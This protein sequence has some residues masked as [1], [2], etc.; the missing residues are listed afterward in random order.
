MKRLIAFASVLIVLGPACGKKGDPRAPEL[1][2][3]QVIKNLTARPDRTGVVL[4]WSRPAEYKDGREIKDLASFVIFRK[5]LS[6][7]CPDCPVAY[8]PLTTVFVEDREKFVQQKQYRYIDE[9]VQ[10]NKI[11]RYRVSSQLTDGSLSEPS[12]EVEIARGTR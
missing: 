6:Q 11:Y 7:T 4:T 5:E 1:A 10:P 2:T 12:N 9:E 3:P 8:K